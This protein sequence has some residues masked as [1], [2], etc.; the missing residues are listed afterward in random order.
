[1]SSEQPKAVLRP[2]RQWSPAV[3]NFVVSLVGLAILTLAAFIFNQSVPKDELEVLPTFLMIGSAYFVFRFH[4]QTAQ[5]FARRIGEI[6]SQPPGDIRSRQ[7]GGQWAYRSVGYLGTAL[8]GA[9]CGLN[10]WVLICVPVWL[11]WLVFY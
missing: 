8:M 3:F 10:V 6:R 4:R 2:K 7:I 11:L 5:D 9:A 1:M